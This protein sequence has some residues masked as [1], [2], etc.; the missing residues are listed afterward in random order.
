MRSRKPTEPL[1][2]SGLPKT[3]FIDLDGTVLVHNPG[4][5]E[6]D[7]LLPGVKEF[8]A[9]A[10]RLE[11]RVILV[12]ARDPQFETATRVFLAMQEL[13]F[14]QLIMGL[15]T[16]ERIVINDKKPSGL[17]TAIAINVLRNGG[18]DGVEIKVDPGL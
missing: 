2:L 4:L 7:R 5:A 9:K 13:R 18:L 14:D 1:K 17:H 3:W 15:P 12:T 6:P 8:W 11:D 16:G 10:I